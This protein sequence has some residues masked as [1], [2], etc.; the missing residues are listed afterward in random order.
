MS[1]ET[2]AAKAL[3]APVAEQE[4]SWARALRVRQWLHFLVLPVAGVD[5]SADARVSAVALARGVALAF[6][7]L[8]FGY[9]VNAIGDRFLD[10]ESAKNPLAGHALPDLRF[11]GALLVVMAALSVT[12]AW[13]ASQPVL[14][15]T[16][17]C[18]V[19]GLVYSV[20]PRLKR[21]P[22]LGTAMNAT[23]FG[24]LL[25]LGLAGAAAPAGLWGITFVF[26]CLILQSQLVHEVQDRAEDSAGRVRT[27]VVAFGEGWVAA[28]AAALGLAAAVL[29]ATLLG[30]PVVGAALLLGF[31]IAFPIA[32]QRK[33][34]PQ[35]L[36]AWHRYGAV[37][38]GALLFGAARIFG[39]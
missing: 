20:G 14:L 24:P 18:L 35:A 38:A 8:G 32:L 17:I 29:T 11:G 25:W 22:I 6:L 27:S 21:F 34:R 5:L 28:G 37:A 31:G 1:V 3:L 19:S 23:H 10:R 2:E 33:A 9:L 39:S 15:A 7:L 36:R 4:V 12:L 16:G 26:A 30:Q 13:T